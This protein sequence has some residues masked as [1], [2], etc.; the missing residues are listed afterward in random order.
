[1]RFGFTQKHQVSHLGQGVVTVTLS[2]LS[3]FQLFL[4]SG[5]A[6]SQNPVTSLPGRQTFPLAD[7]SFSFSQHETLGEIPVSRGP[8]S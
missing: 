7:T 3:L 6:G 4:Q 5:L 1:M 8:F 2:P